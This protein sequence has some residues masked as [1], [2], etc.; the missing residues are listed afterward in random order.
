M[1]ALIVAFSAV[2]AFTGCIDGPAEA[3]LASIKDG[4]IALSAYPAGSPTTTEVDVLMGI[5][6]ATGDQ[7]QDCLRVRDTTTLTA[8]GVRAQMVSAGSYSAGTLGEASECELPQFRIPL[9]GNQ[10][11]VDGVIDDGTGQIHFVLTV[12]GAGVPV[13]T[14]CDGA[15]CS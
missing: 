9:V 11:T 6:G 10:E 3:P 5:A 7:P 14:L 2:L 12:H 13:F 1:K 15:V 4:G 8:N